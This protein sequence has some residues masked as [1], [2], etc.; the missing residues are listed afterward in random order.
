MTIRLLVS[1][2]AF[3]PLLVNAQ[4]KG[5]TIKGNISGLPN[6]TEV[7]LYMED[8]NSEPIAKASSNNGSFELKGTVADPY[9]YVLTY[10][11]KSKRLPIFL[12]NSIIKVSGD[13]SSF[14]RATIEGGETQKDFSVFNTQFS[15]LFERLQVVANQINQQT[16]D[17]EGK[18]RAEYQNL[19]NSI[20]TQTDAFISERR[21]S[22]VAPF[23]AMVANQLQPEISVTQRRYDMLAAEVKKTYFGT[24]L[25]KAI[26]DASVGAIG[27]VAL[28]FIQNDPEGKPVSLSSFRGKYVLIDFWASWCRPC[29]QENPNVVNAYN[30]FKSK[31]FT[32]LGVSL[33]REKAA[34]LKAISDDKLTWTH[35]S[36]LKFW[37]NEVAQKYKVQSIPQNFLVGPDGKILAANLRGEQ[38]ISQLESLLK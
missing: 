18:L 31:N 14:P 22:Y 24:M 33:D 3:L 35:V 20:Q 12:D 29:R 32:V 27:S 37:S 13:A 17:P 6:G 38:L 25:N 1:L 36:D 19:I 23:A 5:F 8:V 2:V 28:D 30:R 16:P 21:S 15:P 26:E 4:V 10:G 9:I 34:W 11:D 7:A